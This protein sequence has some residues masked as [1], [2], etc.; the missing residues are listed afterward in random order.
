VA[1]ALLQRFFKWAYGEVVAIG[2]GDGPNDVPFLRRMEIP[3]VVSNPAAGTTDELIHR[4]P[5]ARVTTGV[6]PAGWHEA[7]AGIFT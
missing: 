2:L 7:I 4:V 6:G 1:V 3:V 5:S